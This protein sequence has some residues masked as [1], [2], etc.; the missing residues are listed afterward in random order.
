MTARTPQLIRVFARYEPTTDPIA[1]ANLCRADL[2]R[3]R[4]VAI[5]RDAAATQ[6]FARFNC[7]SKRPNRRT[8]V[9]TLNCW[10]W[11]LNWLPA[12]PQRANSSELPTRR[13]QATGAGRS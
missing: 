7:D 12:M 13:N 2:A 8:S 9:V 1:K 6:A 10:S 3:A 5:Y 11:A 4:D